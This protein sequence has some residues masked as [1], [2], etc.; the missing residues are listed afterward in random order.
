MILLVHNDA[1]IA[2]SRKAIVNVPFSGL[3]AVV[4]C[5]IFA[6]NIATQ[7]TVR[8]STSLKCSRSDDVNSVKLSRLL[9]NKKYNYLLDKNFLDIHPNM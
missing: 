6:V 8:I 5:Y 4:L 9:S 1:A 7:P 3:S 2:L